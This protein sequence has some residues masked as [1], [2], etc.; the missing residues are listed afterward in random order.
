MTLDDI[1]RA[2][3]LLVDRYVERGQPDAALIHLRALL[4]SDAL[5]AAEQRRLHRLQPV[6]L[7]LGSRHGEARARLA[8]V[9]DGARARLIEQVASLTPA[10]P[11]PGALW[12]GL[13][14]C[15]GPRRTS[16]SWASDACCA[17]TVPWSCCISPCRRCASGSG[18]GAG[19]EC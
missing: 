8:D 18:G 7:A 10:P 16:Y 12:P 6:L 3:S 19:S 13:V 9:D 11:A 1:A 5:P 14:C 15:G 4:G 2:R 17:A